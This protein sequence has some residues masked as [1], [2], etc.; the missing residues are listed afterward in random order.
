MISGIVAD[1]EVMYIDP[2]AVSGSAFASGSETCGM[3]RLRPCHLFLLTPDRPSLTAVILRRCSVRIF[4]LS[5]CFRPAFRR[6]CVPFCH[7]RSPAL[8]RY[9]FN[10]FLYLTNVYPTDLKH[11]RCHRIGTWASRC[12]YPPPPS[13]VYYSPFISFSALL[14]FLFSPVTSPLFCLSLMLTFAI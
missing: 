2:Q 13:I 7:D 8:S 14:L 12:G 1:D 10:V 5:I 6:L 3:C 4:L 11:H 9:L